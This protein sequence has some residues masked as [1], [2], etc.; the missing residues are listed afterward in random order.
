M[1]RL[2]YPAMYY[3]NSTHRILLHFR[4]FTFLAD[5]GD[6]IYAHCSTIV[7][8]KMNSTAFGVAK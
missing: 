2:I 6:R 5:L 1:I 7:I 8:A 3:E 4:V